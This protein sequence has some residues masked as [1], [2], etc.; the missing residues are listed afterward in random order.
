MQV[1]GVPATLQ[2]TILKNYT[3]QEL[4]DLLANNQQFRVIFGGEFGYTEVWREKCFLEFSTPPAF[5]DLAQGRL[6]PLQRYLEIATYHVLSPDSLR[7]C[8]KVYLYTEARRRADSRAEKYFASL[9]TPEEKRCAKEES[10]VP[11]P[12][13]GEGGGDYEDEDYRSVRTEQGDEYAFQEMLNNDDDLL[14]ESAISSGRIDF[15]NRALLFRL[16]DLPRNFNL[17]D[18]VQKNS[19]EDGAWLPQE[20]IYLRRLPSLLKQVLLADQELNQDYASILQ[21]AVSSFNLIILDFFLALY[22][23]HPSVT[24]ELENF[25]ERYRVTR[26]VLTAYS[27]LQRI[28]YRVA[29]DGLLALSETG[30]TDLYLLVAQRRKY[31]DAVHVLSAQGQAGNYLF[32]QAVQD[33]IQD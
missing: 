10:Y 19:I 18:Y 30:N 15:V 5:F 32:V 25:V 8:D 3:V 9:L 26:D 28:R 16:P 17:A 13:G 6:S 27:I 2:S 31:D 20:H 11:L 22:I 29:G 24:Y 12:L 33:L 23:D 1:T 4:E 14:L 7:I 21:S